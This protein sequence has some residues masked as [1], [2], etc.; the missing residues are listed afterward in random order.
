MRLWTELFTII[1]FRPTFSAQRTPGADEF[2]PLLIFTILKA[3]PP[4]LLSNLLYIQR[5][6]HPDKLLSEQGY[7]FTNL[8]RSFPSI[9]L[10]SRL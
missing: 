7:Y 2:L 5:F 4:N 9:E 8:V 3:N 10:F 6:R 1:T